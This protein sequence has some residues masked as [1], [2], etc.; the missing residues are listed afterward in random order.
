MLSSNCDAVALAP[1]KQ[2]WRPKSE[3]W[4]A[5][6]VCKLVFVARSTNYSATRNNGP[7]RQYGEL[8]RHELD[9]RASKTGLGY[10]SGCLAMF[11]LRQLESH[12]A[13]LPWREQ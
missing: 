6:D 9:L 4:G 8:P 12:R 1:W 2:L 3:L 13:S 5:S 10:A 11:D 7:K